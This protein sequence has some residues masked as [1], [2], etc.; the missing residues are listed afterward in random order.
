MKNE[1]SASENET[2]KIVRSPQ[3]ISERIAFLNKQENVHIRLAQIERSHFQKADVIYMA[4]K[5]L[6]WVLGSEEGIIDKYY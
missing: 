5:E 3:E 6:E 1:T 4:I 2:L